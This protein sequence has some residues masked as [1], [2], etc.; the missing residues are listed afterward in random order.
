MTNLIDDIFISLKENNKKIL[1]VSSKF[2]Y[3]QYNEQETITNDEI[4]SENTRA[5]KNKFIRLTLPVG[6][7]SNE[8]SNI[9]QYNPELF[10]LKNQNITKNSKIY[11][12]LLEDLIKHRNNIILDVKREDYKKFINYYS[13]FKST[14]LF[15]SNQNNNNGSSYTSINSDFIEKYKDLFLNIGFSFNKQNEKLF[16]IKNVIKKD[17]PVDFNQEVFVDSYN[18]GNYFPDVI[19][20]SEEINYIDG[21]TIS[22]DTRN[23]CIRCGVYLEKYI[24][25]NEKYEFKSGKFI[26][27]QDSEDNISNVETVFEDTNIKYGKTYMYVIRDVYIFKM[28]VYQNRFLLKTFLLCDIPFITD[29]IVCKEF[30]SPPPPGNLFFKLKTNGLNI[31]WSKVMDNHQNDVRGFQILRRQSLEEPFTLIRQLEGHTEIDFFEVLEEVSEELK[32]KTPGV[33][34]YNYTDIGYKKDKFYIYAIRSIDAHGMLS[35]YSAQFGILHDS[36]NDNL[37]VDIVVDK[38]SPIDQPNLNLVTNSRFFKER[39]SLIDNTPVKA[40]PNKI[41]LYYTP[42]YSRIVKDTSISSDLEQTTALYD[43]I[44]STNKKEYVF[45]MFKINENIEFKQ[46]FSIEIEE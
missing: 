20:L 18:N 46:E 42:E 30:I 31:F 33:V 36:F 15:D 27:K 43:S 45:S 24:K 1:D 32:L 34:P 22:E 16:N 4:I 14:D 26:T 25:I 40:S 37:I 17:I 3:N 9:S 23:N 35:K 41:S 39:D 38:N 28:P 5:F 12:N 8:N 2:I 44:G 11:L 19:P 6:Y 7:F 29:D 13:T 21:S 10:E